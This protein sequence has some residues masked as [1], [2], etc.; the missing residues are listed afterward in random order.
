MNVDG[1]NGHVS[2][3]IDATNG[4]VVKASASPAAAVSSSAT[5]AKQQSLQQRTTS[6]AMGEQLLPY[7]SAVPYVHTPSV[8]N[9]SFRDRDRS[10]EIGTIE[11][12]SFRE[13]EKA[14]CIRVEKEEQTRLLAREAW[15]R[16]QCSP[17]H[18]VMPRASGMG[19][20]F[21]TKKDTMCELIVSD[22][23]LSNQ[24]RPVDGV[25]PIRPQQ[26]P[27]AK[28]GRPALRRLD[29]GVRRGRVVDQSEWRPPGRPSAALEPWVD[30]THK[31]NG[32]WA[33]IDFLHW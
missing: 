19:S 8:H 24:K 14:R 5:S 9:H 6:E 16:G 28:I 29:H 22:I 25:V 33:A 23:R 20:R 11:F 13:S 4:A 31:V 15:Q 10:K 27:K 18:L 17:P 7:L 3:G 32:H 30:H 26:S 2:F 1:G 21:E 12:G